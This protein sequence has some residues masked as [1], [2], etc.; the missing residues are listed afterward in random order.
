MFKIYT[1]IHKH[2]CYMFRSSTIIRELVLSLAKVMSEHL[3]P[4][5]N[6]NL[7]GLHVDGKQN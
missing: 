7:K 2:R 3:Y 5:N 1:T 4:Y 6:K